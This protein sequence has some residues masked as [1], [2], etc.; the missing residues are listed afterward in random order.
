MNTQQNGS[1]TQHGERGR[2]YQTRSNQNNKQK[3]WDFKAA[4]K[5]LG[6]ENV[7]CEILHLFD[8]QC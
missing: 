1:H 5:M 3:S 6:R 2:Y 8:K 4:I 7:S